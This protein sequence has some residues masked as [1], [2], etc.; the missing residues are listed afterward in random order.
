LAAG[1]HLKALPLNNT[2]L[3]SDFF[4]AGKNGLCAPW[5]APWLADRVGGRLGV[6]VDE[7]IAAHHDGLRERAREAVARRVAAINDNG[8]DP[9]HALEWAAQAADLP[10]DE[11]VAVVWEFSPEECAI[12]G[13]EHL[14]FLAERALVDFQRIPACRRAARDEA[15]VRLATVD[16]TPVAPVIEA[17]PPVAPHP[18]D[19]MTAA[20]LTML[21][22]ARS[23]GLP[24]K[25]DQR[26]GGGLV[27]S[28]G[29]T[30]ADLMAME[31]APIKWVVP[32]YIPEGLTLLAG[33]P[34]I[35]KSWMALGLAL[36]VAG[37]GKAFD[38]IE[39]EP[40]R[41]LYLALEDNFRRI[42]S[43]LQYMG[44]RSAPTALDIMTTWPTVDEDCVPQLELWLDQNPDARLVVVDVFA[45]IKSSKG[46]NRPQYDVDYKDVT[47]LQRLAI[48]RSI[49]IILVHHTRKMESEDP[50]DAVSGTRGLTGSADST[51]VLTRATGQS[52]PALYGRGR[53]IEEIEREMEFNPGN[54]HWTVAGPVLAMAATP[55][56]QV[57]V[58]VL[59][60]ASGPMGLADIAEAAKRSKANVSNM[61]AKLIEAGT[62]RKP[63]TGLYELAMPTGAIRTPWS[64]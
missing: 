39:C 24:S 18:Y 21:A 17:A 11:L 37:G 10:P 43:R 60:M 27:A 25:L 48:D 31:F 22:S 50:F 13:R 40:G 56:R 33:S 47:A 58:D 46:G 62:V 4:K 64:G 1:H 61:L 32:G 52:R 55:E 7:L 45:K 54:G 42:K 29:V 6:A 35:G 8:F 36:A 2:A 15:P 59:K 3:A 34:K 28:K 53:D 41:V 12:D 14:L 63:S 30:A 57:I 16:G 20:E 51:F 26:L 23:A 38:E 5:E 9:A 44:V 49:A 19:R